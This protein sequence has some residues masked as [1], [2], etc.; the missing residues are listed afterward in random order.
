MVLKPSDTPY[1]QFFNGNV[2]RMLVL[3]LGNRTVFEVLFRWFFQDIDYL[4]VSGAEKDLGNVFP[5]VFSTIVPGVWIFIVSEKI[6]R[7]REVD[8][9]L[10]D[11]YRR[12]F[13]NTPATGPSKQLHT[14]ILYCMPRVDHRGERSSWTRD[15]RILAVR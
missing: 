13:S 14:I 7:N 6:F 12:F 4:E 1:L 15:L 5:N 3:N 2:A 10:P 11:R 8:V 9:T